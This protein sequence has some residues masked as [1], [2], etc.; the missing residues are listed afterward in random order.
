MIPVLAATVLF[1]HLHQQPDPPQ[2]W[3]DPGY[4]KLVWDQTPNFNQRPKDTVIDTIVLHHTAGSTLG[5]TVLWFRRPESQVSAHFTV[6]KDGSIVQHLSTFDRAWHAGVSKDHLGRENLNNFSIGIEMVNTGV[7]NDP[8][9]TE[10]VNVV[11]FLCAHLKKR[12][13]TIK[14]IT[15]HEFIAEPQGRKN[16]PK[17]FPWERMKPLGLEMYYGQKPKP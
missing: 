7:N 6:G 2:G 10:Q 13:P 16:D 17:G 14:Y 12:F 9:P 4:N 15:S 8:W 11:Y 5:G 3:K 1:D